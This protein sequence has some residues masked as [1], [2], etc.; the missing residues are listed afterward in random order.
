[1]PLVALRPLWS[2][3]Q[4]QRCMGVSF[5]ISEPITQHEKPFNNNLAGQAQKIMRKLT[6]LSPAALLGS[7]GGRDFGRKIEASLTKISQEHEVVRLQLHRRDA[8][9]V[10]SID[11]YEEI[12]Q[13]KALYAE[14]IERFKENEIAEATDEYENL[15]QRITSPKSRQAA[16]MLFSSTPEKLRETYQS[17]KTETK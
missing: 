4:Q 9:I 6:W 13:M 17:G 12:V 10:M 15:Y 3:N 8:A 14:L 1:M 2:Y 11:H 7:K 16:D 5:M